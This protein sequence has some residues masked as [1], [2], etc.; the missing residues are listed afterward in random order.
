MDGLERLE[1]A[2]KSPPQT[3]PEVLSALEKGSIDYDAAMRRIR[4]LRSR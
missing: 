1:A 3:L 4:E 2:A